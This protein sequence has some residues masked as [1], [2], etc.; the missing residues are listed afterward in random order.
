MAINYTVQASVVDIRSDAPQTTDAF[1]VDTNVWLWVAY[2]RASAGPNPPFPDKLKDYPGYIKKALIAR[3]KLYR[4]GLS[5]AELA[6]LIESTERGIYEAANPALKPATF[7]NDRGWT[8][9]KEFR[10]NLPA[11]RGNVVA[12]TRTAWRT[13]QNMAK[14]LT[15]CVDEATTDAALLR[16]QTQPMDGYDL[17]IAEGMAKAGIIQVLTDDG[18]F[19][20]VPGIQVFTANRNVVSAAFAQGKLLKR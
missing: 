4:C 19:C 16:C 17:L 7:A 11:E 3:A 13:V 2:P 20:A 5:M 8:N 14:P 15:V 18:D 10:H 9:P 6:H 12:Q 1:L